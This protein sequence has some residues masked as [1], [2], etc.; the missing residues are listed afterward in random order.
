MAHTP[1]TVLQ[2]LK[3]NKYAPVYFLQGEEPFFIDKI[4]DFIEQ[5]AL[6]EAAKGFNQVVMYG[7]DANLPA[8]M[9][10][11][12][13][14]PMMSERQVVIVKEAQ[15]LDNLEKDQNAKMLEAYVKNPLPSTVLVFAYKGKTLDGRKALAKIID[16]HAIL[17][18]TKKIYDNQVPDWINSM[19]AG[20]G[21]KINP[22][23]AAMLNE[24]VGANLSRLE[25]ETD[26]VIINLKAGETIT[27]DLVSKYVGVSKEYNVFE[28]Q[29]ALGMRN[30]ELCFKIV[31]YFEAN[32]KNNPI[33]QIITLLFQFYN[34]VL[35][36]HA[37]PQKDERTI[38]A[39]LGVNP[40]FVK[41]YMLA[42]RNYNI[43]KTIS[44]I[45]FL[46]EADLLSKGV[47]ATGV[48]EG[49]ILKELMF[50]IL[51]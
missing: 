39:L 43:D 6:D 23:A 16:K 25:N 28:L 48:S 3:Q 10:N 2:D 30:S 5:N 49:E 4:S 46:R 8:V 20:K 1:E 35:L 41:D 24:F 11:A 26:K 51:R 27:E 12:K 7:K 9:N 36:V 44:I 19:V 47:G 45:H 34:K 38:A 18:T 15:E 32:P 31:F 29:K 42:A 13:R 21:Y 37:S 33:Q 17:V 50:K 22:K 14:Y 40:F